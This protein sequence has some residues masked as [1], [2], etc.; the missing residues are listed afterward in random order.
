MLFRIVLCACVKLV[1]LLFWNRY[2]TSERID[3]DID[4]NHNRKVFP[5]ATDE[6]AKPSNNAEISQQKA[7]PDSESTNHEAGEQI[8]IF[9]SQIHCGN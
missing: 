4:V 7:G 8:N 6:I 1:R 5:A 2:S 3:L 9:V